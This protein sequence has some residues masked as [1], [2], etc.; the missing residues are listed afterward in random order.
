MR[1]DSF[2]EQDAQKLDLSTV[3]VKVVAISDVV[4]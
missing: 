2:E 3:R 1:A 4:G